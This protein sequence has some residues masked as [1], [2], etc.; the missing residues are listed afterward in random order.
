MKRIHL[1]AGAVF[2]AIGIFVTFQG[3]HLRLEGQYGPGPGFFPFWIGLGVTALSAV[4]LVQV[5][6][7]SGATP[8]TE[9]DGER[10]RLWRL[11]AIVAALVAFAAALRTLGFDLSMLGLLL[12]LSFLIDRQHA[13]A[14]IVIALLGSF[15]LHY[16][17][18]QVLRVP[19]PYASIPFLNQLGF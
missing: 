19:L 13:I 8:A 9:A 14:K 18:E 15:G 10:P 5:L 16:L 1:V 12:F 2:A 17:F 6:A 3:Y 4:W 11:A 7:G